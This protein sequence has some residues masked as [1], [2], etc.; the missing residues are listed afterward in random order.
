MGV[1]SQDIDRALRLNNT[2]SMQESFSTANERNAN[3]ERPKMRKMKDPE[4]AWAAY[5][6]RTKKI[7]SK[8]KLTKTQFMSMWYPSETEKGLRQSGADAKI[9][10]R[11]MGS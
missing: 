5:Q 4:A 11:I 7:G 1:R 10:R 3:L 6:K 2:G 8:S 9:I